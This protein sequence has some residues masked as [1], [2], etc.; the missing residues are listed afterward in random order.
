MSVRKG[1][2]HTLAAL[3]D[4][5]HVD[6]FL[7]R[8]FGRRPLHVPG[9][10]GKFDALL[11]PERFIHGLDRVAEIRCVFEGLRQATIGPLDIREMFEAGATICV[12]GMEQ[13]HPALQ[14]AARR[15]EQEIGFAGRVDF[16]AYL[17]PPGTGFG[18]HYDARTA[19]SLQL[20]GTKTWWYSTLPETEF[21]THN[22]NRG[23]TAA[24]LRAVARHTLRRVTLKPGHLL[25]LPPGVWHRAEAG[26][27]GSLA[28]NLAFN[29]VGGTVG[30]V[31]A[32]YLREALGPVAAA[33][34]PFWTGC[35]DSDRTVLNAQIAE[36]IAG[37][38]SAIARLEA[39]R[40]ATR[41]ASVNRR[42]RRQA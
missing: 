33:Q 36:S 41:L 37:I 7:A 25:C 17:S 39:V 35:A 15:I 29:H 28:L 8:Y 16:R 34:R 14:R 26:S 23:D 38:K 11:K 10:P 12:T 3:L 20:Q 31:L 6:A 32:Q 2:A 30:D 1:K 24:T 40:P 9:A 27:G 19:T 13:A 21:P 5:L 22:S 18:F 4:P 42:A